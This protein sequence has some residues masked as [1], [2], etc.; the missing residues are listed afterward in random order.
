[1]AK[2]L[3]RMWIWSQEMP[4]GG[5]HVQGLRSTALVV[6]IVLPLRVL[7]AGLEL[8]QMTSRKVATLL[9]IK[10][11]MA[12]PKP[13]PPI[14]ATGAAPTVSTLAMAPGYR[15]T[16]YKEI[17]SW[18]C[19]VWRITATSPLRGL[20]GAAVVG[21]FFGDAAHRSSGAVLLM[22]WLLLETERRRPAGSTATEGDAAIAHLSILINTV[23]SI[24]HAIRRRA[25][26]Q[27]G[28]NSFAAS[29]PSKGNASRTTLNTALLNANGR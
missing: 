6:D 3:I 23:L 15:L 17:L 29:Q 7:R 9:T 26:C 10:T 16:T 12:L 28:S 18:A 25:Q 24:G 2:L 21:L 11:A 22:R 1:M 19:D 4:A 13:P 27:L 20:A 5:R 8:S 14:A